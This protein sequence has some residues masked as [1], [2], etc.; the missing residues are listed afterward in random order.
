MWNPGSQIGPTHSWSTVS[1]EP[2]DPANHL[3]YSWHQHQPQTEEKVRLFVKWIKN[4]KAARN[5][6]IHV[7]T[8]KANTAAT[9]ITDHFRNIQEKD[10]I[11]HDWNKALI[12]KI[13]KISKDF[14][15]SKLNQW[16]NWKEG[17]TRQQVNQVKYWWPLPDWPTHACSTRHKVVYRPEE[18]RITFSGWSDLKLP[19]TLSQHL[20]F[21][22]HVAIG[23]V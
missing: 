4:G 8:L 3:W 7:K 5:D 20:I 17:T 12:V 13:P 16:T 14:Q 23:D 22:I 19:K 9:V 6:F 2:K 21:M 11:P 18:I 1:L 15:D 10:I